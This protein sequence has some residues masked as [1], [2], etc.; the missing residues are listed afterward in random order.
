MVHIPVCGSSAPVVSGFTADRVLCRT[1]SDVA[2]K[3][4]SLSQ[5]KQLNAYEECIVMRMG[6]KGKPL[7]L[8]FRNTARET[9]QFEEVAAVVLY[10]GQDHPQK[11]Q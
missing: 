5:E 2:L 6:S 7:R 1:Y 9:S 4:G 10:P 3:P 8:L 11:P